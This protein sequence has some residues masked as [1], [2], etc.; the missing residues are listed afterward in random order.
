MTTVLLQPQWGH[1]GWDGFRWNT[2]YSKD[3]QA[4][5]FLNSGLKQWLTV[6]SAY[7]CSIDHNDKINSNLLIIQ[8]MDIPKL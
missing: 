4:F 2:L 5:I 7:K 3:D 8:Y 6:C 1:H